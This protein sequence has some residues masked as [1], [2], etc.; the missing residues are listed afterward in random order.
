MPGRLAPVSDFPDD[1]FSWDCWVLLV[2]CCRLV[3]HRKSEMWLQRQGWNTRIIT[4]FYFI[5]WHC[6]VFYLK[7]VNNTFYLKKYRATASCNKCLSSLPL[8]SLIAWTQKTP[9]NAH[10]RGGS[11]K[12]Y[13][14]D[15]IR[16]LCNALQLFLWLQK[17]CLSS[18]TLT[19]VVI[20]PG[21]WEDEQ[22]N[23]WLGGYKQC[24]EQ[25]ELKVQQ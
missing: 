15:K 21:M 14:S 2:F 19:A 10:T 6:N 23:L 12:R 11:D 22:V 5:N 4:A 17:T 9:P 16:T 18:V 1:P 25:N 20:P 13:L 8:G 24:T 3:C 7:R